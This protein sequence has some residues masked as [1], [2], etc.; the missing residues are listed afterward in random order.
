MADISI[1][2]MPSTR[3]FDLANSQKQQRSL[4]HHPPKDATAPYE[5]TIVARPD[6]LNGPPGSAQQSLRKLSPAFHRLQESASSRRVDNLKTRLGIDHE[7]C[8]A[9]TPR[10]AMQITMTQSSEE[11]DCTLESP[12]GM[13]HLRQQF[14]CKSERS[15]RR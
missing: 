3:D 9:L 10:N 4:E 15:K 6:V 14:L 12:V 8:R 1:G 11:L 13:V 7:Y 5:A 2:Q